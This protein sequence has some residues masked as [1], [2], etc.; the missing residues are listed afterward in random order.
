MAHWQRRQQKLKRKQHLNKRKKSIVK[1][2]LMDFRIV[3]V[4]V[5][6]NYKCFI[7]ISEEET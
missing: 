5:M 2:F 7:K 3:I 4:K 1:Q 6:N